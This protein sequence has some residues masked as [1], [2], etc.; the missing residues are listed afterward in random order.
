MN[1]TEVPVQMVVAEAEIATA[2]ITVGFTVM[3]TEFEFVDAGEAQ[4]AVEFI[5]Q[6][7]TSPCAR[8]ELV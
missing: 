8:V 3:V 6:V 2:G 5:T 1:V 4:V 7:T